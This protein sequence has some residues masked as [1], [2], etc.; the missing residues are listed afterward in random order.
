VLLG[1]VL[2]DALSWSWIFF[3]NV[4]VGVGAFFLAPVSC[5]EPRRVGQVVRRLGAVLVTAGLVVAR[6]RDHAGGTVRL[7]SGRR[8][9]FFA[10]R[11]SCSS[12]S[13]CGSGVT[14]S[15]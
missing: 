3:V 15:R 5:G 9:A 13:S 6:L 2:T 12:A 1:G 7:G 4:P 11:P 10:H 8:S 14:P